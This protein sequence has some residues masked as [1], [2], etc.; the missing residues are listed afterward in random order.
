MPGVSLGRGRRGGLLP[1]GRPRVVDRP[2]RRQVCAE[3]RTEPSTLTTD[4]TPGRA[5]SCGGGLPRS[6]S[7]IARPGDRLIR[8]LARRVEA[9]DT[10]GT[11]HLSQ[12]PVPRLG[13]KGRC[14]RYSLLRGRRREPLLP[15]ARRANLPC[16]AEVE[17][18]L[19][20]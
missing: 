8:V 16:C 9:R 17:A 1:A 14:A 7:A 3:G 6:R 5:S 20:P 11:R 13:A 2:R 18:V 15:G 10:T 12:R 4:L 19:A